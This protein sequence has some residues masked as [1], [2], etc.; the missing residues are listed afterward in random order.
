MAAKA[1]GKNGEGDIQK[2][3]GGDENGGDSEKD[4]DSETASREVLD[5][6]AKEIDLE[7]KAL[8]KEMRDAIKRGMDPDRFE[9]LSAAAPEE[10]EK[11]R[12]AIRAEDYFVDGEDDDGRGYGSYVYEEVYNPYFGNDQVLG[13]QAG[14]PSK[15]GAG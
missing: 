2:N 8:R 13:L 9:E 4:T 15:V 12:T 1:A 3:T 14:E 6:E 10:K 7:R 5:R 11:Q